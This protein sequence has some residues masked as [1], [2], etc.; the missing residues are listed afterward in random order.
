MEEKILESLLKR[1]GLEDKETVLVDMIQDSMIEMR[2][3]LNYKDGEE[4]PEGCV[5]AVKELTLI[6]F[7]QDGVEGVS[8]ESQSSGGSTTYLES[9]PKT[10]RQA[11]RRYRKFRR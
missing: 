4:L 9:L 7:N 8:S 2:T 1:P 11:V 5:P 6:R 3:L 10:V